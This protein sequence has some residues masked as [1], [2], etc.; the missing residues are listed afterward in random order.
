MRYQG[1]ALFSVSALTC[2]FNAGRILMK[3]SRV[4]AVDIFNI[5]MR[6]IFTSTIFF[7]VFPLNLKKPTKI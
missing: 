2:S 3:G 5:T 7:I 1:I 4:C 6:N